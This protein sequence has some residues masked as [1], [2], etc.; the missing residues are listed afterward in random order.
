MSAVVDYSKWD[1]LDDSDDDAAAPAEPSAAPAAPD[2]A[3]QAT[4][5][6]Q[7]RSVPD[8]AQIATSRGRGPRGPRHGRQGR[9]DPARD[10]ARRFWEENPGFDFGSAEFNGQETSWEPPEGYAEAQL[11]K[12][13]D[14]GPPP[15]VTP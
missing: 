8:G 5:A 12:R 2:E 10:D 15:E 3:V 7:E 14:D 1:N 6:I 13:D 9:G 4:P 11:A